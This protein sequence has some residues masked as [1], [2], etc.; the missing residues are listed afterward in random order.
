MEYNVSSLR[1]YNCRE[2]EEDK[3]IPHPRYIVQDTLIQRNGGSSLWKS[4]P[5]NPASLNHVV[6]YT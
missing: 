1:E 3:M 6:K 2:N 5:S 4:L